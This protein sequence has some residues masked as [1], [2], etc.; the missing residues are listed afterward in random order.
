[1]KQ[2]REI[3]VKMEIDSLEKFSA[4]EQYFSTLNIGSNKSWQEIN[5][6]AIYYDTEE[7]SL[8]E[9]KA[10][11]RVRQENKSLVATYKQGISNKNG[12]AERIEIN[13]FVEKLTPDITVFKD[14]KTVWPLL[15]RLEGKKLEPIVMTD[16]IRKALLID[17]QDS[18]IEV[19]LDK[20]IIV[21]GKKQ[22]PICELE[23]E[24]KFGKTSSLIDLESKINNKFNLTPS[25][26]SKYKRGLILAGL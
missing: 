9:Y 18:K 20:G 23:L 25:T 3:E 13:K 11:Y 16:F 21:G 14:E 4:I 10:A 8:Q 12:I 24:L 1:M 15:Q 5:M 22:T 2:Q 17:W 6:K 26:V 7:S 19:S